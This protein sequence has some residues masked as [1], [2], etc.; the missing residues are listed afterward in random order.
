[1]MIFMK[2]MGFLLIE[3]GKVLVLF[4][5]KKERFVGLA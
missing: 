3:S 1:M 4:D 2:F 5:A